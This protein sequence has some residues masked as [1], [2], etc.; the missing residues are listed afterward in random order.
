MSVIG[1]PLPRVDGEQKVTGEARYSAE[2]Q[3]QKLAYSVMVMS[4]VPSAQ[5]VNIDTHDA[6]R[7]FP[8]PGG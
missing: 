5:I 7:A 8:P 4:T 1:A 6:E 3:A 2:F